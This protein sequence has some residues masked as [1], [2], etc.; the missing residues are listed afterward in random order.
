LIYKSFVDILSFSISKIAIINSLIYF[1]FTTL[2]TLVYGHISPAVI[3]DKL[4]VF[5]KVG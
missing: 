4:V 1:N 2:K 5:Y 3:I